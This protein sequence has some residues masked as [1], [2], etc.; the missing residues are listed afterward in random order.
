VFQKE[1]NP[2]AG[3]FH[4]KQTR[5]QAVSFFDATWN[6]WL[7]STEQITANYNIVD[8][9]PI[10]NVWDTANGGGNPRDSVMAHF[11]QLDIGPEVSASLS[12]QNRGPIK[13]LLNT[14]NFKLTWQNV[15]GDFLPGV[16]VS[17][18]FYL[19][20]VIRPNISFETFQGI[21]FKQGA[22]SNYNSNLLCKLLF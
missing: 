19:Q 16:L 1:D 15:N 21:S 6:S 4:Y 3:L 10:L 11:K 18:S 17:Y 20:I 22:L 5:H 14:H 8:S 12:L 7:R 2:A 9:F 13:L